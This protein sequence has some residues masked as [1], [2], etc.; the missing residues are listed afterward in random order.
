[1]SDLK[2]NVGEELGDEEFIIIDPTA[3]PV[4]SIDVAKVNIYKNLYCTLVF[5]HLA[6][7]SPSY[8]IFVLQGNHATGGALSADM[9]D[10][11][12]PSSKVEVNLCPAVIDLK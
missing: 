9:I 4:E 3:S 6:P 1:M 11:S 7:H 10:L 8:I 5:A 12:F 2:V